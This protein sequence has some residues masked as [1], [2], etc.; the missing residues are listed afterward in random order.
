ME[1]DKNRAGLTLGGLLGLVHLFWALLVGFGWAKGIYEWFLKIHFLS[2][3]FSVGTFSFV[4]ALGLIVTAFVVGY[5]VGWV[6]AAIWNWT[7]RFE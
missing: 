1:L 7:D 4:W 5:V 3:N 2:F 6:F